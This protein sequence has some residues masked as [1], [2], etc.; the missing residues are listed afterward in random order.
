MTYGERLAEKRLARDDARLRRCWW[1]GAW[2]L[3]LNDCNECAAPAARPIELERK[4]S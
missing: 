3:G 2:A 1:C 4:T